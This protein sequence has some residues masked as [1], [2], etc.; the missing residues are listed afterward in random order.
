M[1][2]RRLSATALLLVLLAAP[3]WSRQA[4]PV[5]VF[6]LAGQSNMEGFGGLRTLDALGEH[7]ASAEL[8]RRIRKEDGTFVVRDDVLVY[9]KR[10]NEE[11]RAPLTVGFGAHKD[12]FG[13][14]LLF[15]MEMGDAF[16]EP[17]LLV[18]TAWGG[19]DLYCDFRPPGAGTASYAVPGK[20]REAGAYY[21]KLVEELRGCLD[22]LGVHFPAL[23]GRSYE[24]CG[25][26]WFQGWND[27]CADRS[28]QQQ[29]F[30]EYGSNLAHLVRDLR[31]EFKAPRL[32][33]VVG[34]VGVEG[35]R[36]RDGSPMARFRAAQ[37]RIQEHADLKPDLRYVRTAAHWYPALDD[38]P[39]RLHAEESRIRNQLAASLPPGA[40]LDARVKAAL[41]KAL[42]ADEVYARVKAEHDRHVSH[43]ECHYQGS[44]RVYAGVGRDFAV[45]MKD[46]L[47]V[48]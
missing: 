11:I 33:V 25:L 17:V 15:G 37:S 35:E 34:E 6:V 24:L 47:G 43:W 21:R 48:R 10:G 39:R 14:E 27:Y 3:A 26:V 1:I 13:P 28:I 31:A 29:V 20:P 42:Q 30:D 2:V 19:K 23:Q 12:R 4:R 32:K 9:Y 16:E 5:K 44:A 38:L 41:P 7:P 36:V 22:R 45:A 8:L 18:K 40:D 46:L